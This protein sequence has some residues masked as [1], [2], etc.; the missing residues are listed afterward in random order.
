MSKV[1]YEFVSERVELTG[2][3]RALDSKREGRENEQK[4]R[5]K[6]SSAGLR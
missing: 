1:G 5:T 3:N 6:K 2:G 4:T